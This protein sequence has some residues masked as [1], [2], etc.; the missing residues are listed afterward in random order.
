M[1]IAQKLGLLV[2]SLLVAMLATIVLLSAQISATSSEYDS[3]IKNQL[4]QRSVSAAIA[5]SI[6]SAGRYR[7]LPI[8]NAL[9]KQ[10]LPKSGSQ[11]KTLDLEALLNPC[12]PG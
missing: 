7:S 9:Y 8:A 6:G 3:L 2:G 1:K 4:A 11:A 10:L 12:C 5:R